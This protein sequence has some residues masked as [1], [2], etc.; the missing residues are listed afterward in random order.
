MST[1]DTAAQRGRATTDEPNQDNTGGCAW[2]AGAAD[3]VDAATGRP[4]CDD[5]GDLLDASGES[6]LITATSGGAD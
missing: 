2:C 5:C 6:R 1:F 3:G 4:C